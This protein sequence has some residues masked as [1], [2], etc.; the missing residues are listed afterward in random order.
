MKRVIK[1]QLKLFD[2]QKLPSLFYS[3]CNVV[4]KHSKDLSIIISSIARKM[5]RLTRGGNEDPQIQIFYDEFK[6][7]IIH[8]NS[9]YA[10]FIPG[11]GTLNRR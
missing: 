6:H 10:Q 8:L 3:Q 11:P 7:G 1:V 4:V 5:W 2:K 9:S